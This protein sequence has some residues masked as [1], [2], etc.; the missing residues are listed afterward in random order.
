MAN[1][2]YRAGRKRKKRRKKRKKE[3]IATKQPSKPLQLLSQILVKWILQVTQMTQIRALLP[4]FL[5]RSLLIAWRGRI[6]LQQANCLQLLL[7]SMWLGRHLDTIAAAHTVWWE[8]SRGAHPA[9]I[10]LL[11][12][13]KGF[14]QCSIWAVLAVP[15]A[16]CLRTSTFHPSSPQAVSLQC[17]P[18]I[19]VTAEDLCPSSAPAKGLKWAQQGELNALILIWRRNEL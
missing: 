17:P 12:L 10:S 11:P 1:V 13:Q 8:P 6:L 18:P 9:C 19:F 5:P 2:H 3:T 15:I 7:S 16:S 14:D 4:G